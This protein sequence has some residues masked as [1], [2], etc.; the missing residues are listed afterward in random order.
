LRTRI[1]ANK[2]RAEQ[3]KYKGE[4]EEDFRQVG[5][6]FLYDGSNAVGE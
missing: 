3:K 6:G 4:D 2:D 1:E 5:K